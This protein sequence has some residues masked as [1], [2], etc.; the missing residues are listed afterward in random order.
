MSEIPNPTQ[1][2]TENN[3]FEN[4]KCASTNI[5]RDQQNSVA[6]EPLNHTSCLSQA[7]SP[8][9]FV[10]ASKC[11]RHEIYS[12][13]TAST[14]ISH[15]IFNMSTTKRPL[16]QKRVICTSPRSIVARWRNAVLHGRS[17]LKGTVRPDWILHE[18][19]TIG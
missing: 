11:P 15:K 18:S 3:K 4:I 1:T 17:H 12:F 16:P 5:F 6:M 8:T 10:P 14:T 7:S 19:G 9:R 2:V 13:V